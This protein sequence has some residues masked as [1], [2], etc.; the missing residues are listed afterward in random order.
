[1]IVS[2]Q[3]GRQIDNAIASLDALI[4]SREAVELRTSH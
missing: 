1:M 2:N 4:A 3:G